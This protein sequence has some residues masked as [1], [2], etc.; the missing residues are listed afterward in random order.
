MTPTVPQ[1]AEP[2]VPLTA[3]HD[4]MVEA[5]PTADDTPRVL[6]TRG[7]QCRVLAEVLGSGS[8]LRAGTDVAAACIRSRAALL[9][10]RHLTS[11]QLCNIAVPQGFSTTA[12]RSVVAAVGGG[13]HSHLAAAV[14]HRLSQELE[15]PARAIYG[16]HEP[17]EHPQAQTVLDAIT[18]RLP[19]LA[20]ETIRAPNPATMV[21][22]LPAGTLLVV[23]ASGG[24]WFQRQFLGPGARIQAKSTG[25]TIVVRHSP[26]R[27]YQ[28]MQLPAAFGP[29]MRVADAL[30]LSGDQ[31][32]IVAQDGQLLGIVPNECLRAALPDLELRDIMEPPVSLN[33][34]EEIDHA[35]DL[36][37]DHPQSP[38]PVVDAYQR[39]VGTITPPDLDHRPIL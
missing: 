30:H 24:S 29:Y 23:G 2:D 19:D 31:A 36:I 27:I 4:R 3:R 10:A 35:A 7:A 15:V 22:A 11:F 17:D 25:G 32:A 8:A 33:A 28:I 12:T 5:R 26:T 38:I 16:H 34:E 39:L 1:H 18:A 37:G 6:W 13:P 21:S 9:V 14:A 20:V